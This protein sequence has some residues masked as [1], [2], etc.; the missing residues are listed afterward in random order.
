MNRSNQSAAEGRL[1]QAER[2]RLKP[3]GT[4]AQM[5]GPFHEPRTYR[6]GPLPLNLPSGMIRTRSTASHSFQAKS[7]TRWN[8]SLPSSG[9]QGAPKGLVH[10]PDAWPEA[11]EAAYE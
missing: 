3:A 8:A 10:G 11:A 1:G 5:K 6:D 9:A 2:S 7:G 4:Q